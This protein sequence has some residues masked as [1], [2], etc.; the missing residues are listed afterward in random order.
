[1]TDEKTIA[2]TLLSSSTKGGYHNTSVGIGLLKQD[3]NDEF[4]T[5]DAL[6]V[7]LL[8]SCI[9]KARHKAAEKAKKKGSTSGV[10]LPSKAYFTTAMCKAKD[11]EQERNADAILD[12]IRN[13]KLYPVMPVLMRWFRNGQDSI[14]D[15]SSVEEHVAAVKKEVR[16]VPLSSFVLS[17][18][19]RTEKAGPSV[20][21]IT[22]PKGF[23]PVEESSSEDESPFHWTKADYQK[24]KVPRGMKHI[25]LVKLP[26]ITEEQ[27]AEFEMDKLS[28]A[29]QGC[30]LGLD[31]NGLRTYEKD[32]EVS[33]VDPTEPEVVAADL[34][35][36]FT[37]S[38]FPEAMK[39]A[40]PAGDD[41]MVAEVN[42]SA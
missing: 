3:P 2:H 34:P 21:T 29:M 12:K 41:P 30:V 26:K 31:S 32:G 39:A 22:Y 33:L 14:R 28:L 18:D 19:D 13:E 35:S 1:M 7:R 37:A 42:V 38:G 27:Q 5:I 23:T 20:R 6:G 24:S 10:H 17:S 9:T 36:T 15:H 4:V 16:E 11:T 40:N 25:P 8:A